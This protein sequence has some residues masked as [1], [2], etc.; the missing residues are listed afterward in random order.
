MQ[1]EQSIPAE[2]PETFAP[3]AELGQ[4]LLLIGMLV[5]AVGAVL[6]VAVAVV[7]VVAG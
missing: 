2:A 4:S 6:G 5:G 3:V 1:P 7:R